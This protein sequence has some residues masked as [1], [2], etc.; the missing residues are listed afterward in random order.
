MSQF[1]QFKGMKNNG[2][3]KTLAVENTGLEKEQMKELIKINDFLSPLLDPKQTALQNETVF[4][5]P[6]GP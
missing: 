5:K 2:F 1:K 3:H 6:C 4:E